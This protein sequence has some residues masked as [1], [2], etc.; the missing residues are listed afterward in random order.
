M[1]HV[2]DARYSSSTDCIMKTLRAE[3]ASTLRRPRSPLQY[4]GDASARRSTGIVQRLWRPSCA[5]RSPHADI[6]HRIRAGGAITARSVVSIPS[7]HP[8]FHS[9]GVSVAFLRYDM[10][11]YLSPKSQSYYRLARVGRQ[12]CRP[13]TFSHREGRGVSQSECF[14]IRH[15]HVHQYTVPWSCRV[16]WRARCVECAIVP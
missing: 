9:C 12:Q 16:C 8:C 3:G 14:H 11:G 1:L 13:C 2:C 7:S 15:A 5:H 6:I 10:S 4:F